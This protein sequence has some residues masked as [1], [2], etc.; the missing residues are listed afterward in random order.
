MSQ[1]QPQAAATKKEGA[2]T[3]PKE[4]EVSPHRAELKD[5][6]ASLVPA[7]PA[8]TPA[9]A[10][11]PKPAP[12]TV[13]EKTETTI[14]ESITERT[15][16]VSVQ[17]ESVPAKEIPSPAAVIGGPRRAAPQFTAAP[18]SDEHGIDPAV[19]KRMLRDHHQERSPF[20]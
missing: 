14:Q 12:E 5:L 2:E 16:H 8:P 18:Q 1:S 11:A 7:T 3:V 9:P 20:A 17:A 15:V 13:V 6:L 4:K 19:V 10:P